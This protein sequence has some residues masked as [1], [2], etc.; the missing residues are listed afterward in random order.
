LVA[1]GANIPFTPEAENALHERGVMVIPDFIANAGGVM[2]A[3]VEYRGRTQK[4]AFEYIDER[5]RANTKLVLEE[6]RS[7]RCPPR[8]AALAVAEQRV[9]AALATRRWR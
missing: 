5:I 2:C 8:M 3:A 7:K 4:S 9:R 1:Q 6:A